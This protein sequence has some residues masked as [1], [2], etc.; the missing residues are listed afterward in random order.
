MAPAPTAAERIADAADRTGLRRVHV[1]SWRDLDHPDAGGSEIHVNAIAGVWSEAGIDVTILTGGVP[2][3][4][5]RTE[6]DGYRVR[7]SGGRVGVL[8]RSPLASLAGSAGPRDGLVEVW[9]GVNFLAP[10]WARGPRVGIAHHVHGRQFAEVLPPGVSHVA[11][12]LERR[13][14]PRL[15]RSTPLVTLSESNRQEMLALGY[16]PAMVSVAVPGVDGRFTPGGE[17]SPV[18]LVAAVGRLMP[19]K[20]FAELLP[21]LVELRRRHP[22]LRAVVAGEGP[23]R[24]RIEAAVRSSGASGWLE[25]AGRVADGELVD[26]YRR[27]WV[28]ACPSTAEGWGMTVT[29]AAACATPA[30]ATRIAGHVDAVDDGVTGYLARDGRELTERLDALLRDATLRERMGRAAEAK[31]RAF[32]WP[33][34]AWGIFEPLARDAARRR[35]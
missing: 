20:R 9:H 22:E 11:A 25:V 29:E 30:V 15:Y 28:L 10:L 33:E 4:P 12:L 18:P 6:R 27:A 32:T 34:A 16:D 26:L 1:L 21:V 2:G 3:A 35:R 23:E 31:A 14:Y 24:H 8:V 13:A 5:R 19:Q 7:R 17:R